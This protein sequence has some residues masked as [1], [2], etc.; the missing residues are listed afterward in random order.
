MRWHHST[1]IVFTALVACA[2][3]GRI[4]PDSP[5]GRGRAQLQSENY[6]EALTLFREALANVP[7]DPNALLGIGAA[8]EGLGQLDSARAVYAELGASDLPGAARDELVFQT[9]LGPASATIK[10]GE[11]FPSD[12]GI[13]GQVVRTGRSVLVED[14]HKNRNFYPGIDHKAK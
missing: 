7:G 9:V 10:P 4:A 3:P 12:R 1:L 13:A 2:Q 11:R 8:H 5:V 14:V 6:A